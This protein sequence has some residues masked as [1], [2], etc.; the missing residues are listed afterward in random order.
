MRHSTRSAIAALGIAA[1]TVTGAMVATA[2]AQAASVTTIVVAPVGNDLASGDASHPVATLARAQQLARTL[3]SQTD[4]VVDLAGGTYR[5]SAPLV[6]TNA[7]SGRN[8]HTVTWQAMPGQTAAVSGAQPV[9][10]WTLHDSAANIWSA[11]V[12]TGTC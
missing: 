7:D 1:C 8:G 12:P 6:F 4:V 10:G 9:T 3:S 11:P 2:P 5:P